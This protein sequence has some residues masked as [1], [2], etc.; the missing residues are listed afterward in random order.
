[1]G[2]RS[3]GLPDE[4]SKLFPD[5]FEESELGRFHMDGNADRLKDFF[6]DSKRFT[7]PSENVY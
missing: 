4:I 2:E 1:M 6:L 5:S 7:T 3:T